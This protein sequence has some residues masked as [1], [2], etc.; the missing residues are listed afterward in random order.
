[1]AP[2]P[3]VAERLKDLLAGYL[4]PERTPYGE[5]ENFI[6]NRVMLDNAILMVSRLGIYEA[7]GV[8]CRLLAAGNFRLQRRG[9]G[10]GIGHSNSLT[11]EADGRSL[12]RLTT[13][14]MLRLPPDRIPDFWAKLKTLSTSRDLLPV[15]RQL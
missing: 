10:P 4:V 9:E 8:I 12:V 5:R 11:P 1:S 7:H 6:P 14:C 15:V 13:D 2:F 3:V